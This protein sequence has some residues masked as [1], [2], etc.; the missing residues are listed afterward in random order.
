MKRSKPFIV[1]SICLSIMLQMAFAQ[2]LS[3]DLS[4]QRNASFGTVNFFDPAKADNKKVSTMSYADV[5]G[6][7]FLHDEWRTAV[8]YL[9]SG[10]SM[11]FPKARLN[12]YT[13][14][15]HYLANVDVEMAIEPDKIDK[16]IIFDAKDSTKT[17]S[18]YVSL[19]DH[20]N[21]KPFAFFKVFN[22]G[23][24]QLLSLQKTMVKTSPYD[25]LEGKKI[26]SF[27]SKTYYAIYN[28]G[29]VIP[30]K[31]LDHSVIGEAIHLSDQD[32]NWLKQNKNK[33]RSEHDVVDFLAYYNQ[34]NK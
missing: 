19:P 17:G 23:T 1:L 4:Y 33:L 13:G 18:F 11:L 2:Q 30:I 6:S 5:V 34:L 24:F 15:L 16:F 31:G 10:K 25:P 26:S 28:N 7:P 3:I 12:S 32:E 21:S 22:N 14:E 9:K 8:V 27:F 29:R 20:I